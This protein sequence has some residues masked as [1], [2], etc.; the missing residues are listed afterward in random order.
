MEKCADFRLVAPGSVA[1]DALV[2]V[3]V[4]KAF[5]GRVAAVAEEALGTQFPAEFGGTLVL[6]VLA[7]L[8]TVLEEVWRAAE[9]THVVGE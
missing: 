9:V 3:G 2:F 8:G 5:H 7:V 6:H 4:V 1:E